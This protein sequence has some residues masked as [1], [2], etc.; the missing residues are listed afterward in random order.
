MPVKDDWCSDWD[1]ISLPGLSSSRIFSFLVYKV[2]LNE[3]NSITNYST[4]IED[5]VITGCNRFVDGMGRFKQMCF[6]PE[7]RSDIAQVFDDK[8]TKLYA[9]IISVSHTNNNNLCEKEHY[10]RNEF[11]SLN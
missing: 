1:E 7:N 2:F 3:C 5:P 4:S 9:E 6:L 8:F 10:N 11:I